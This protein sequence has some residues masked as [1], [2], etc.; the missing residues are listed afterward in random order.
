MGDGGALS[1]RG[2]D[3][4][5]SL[6]MRSL[7]GVHR[8]NDGH[9]VGVLSGIFKMLTKLNAGNVSRDCFDGA[10]IGFGSVGLGI[11]S[12]D[13]SHASSHVEV[14]DVLGFSLGSGDCFG[15]FS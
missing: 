11:K 6:S 13:M 5:V 10:T 2:V 1:V 14:D 12:I 8:A 4:V 9:L 7:S 3:G 15:G